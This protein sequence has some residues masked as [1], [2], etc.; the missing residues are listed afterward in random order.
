DRLRGL[1]DVLARREAAGDTAGFD[2]LR[3]EREVLDLDADL[4]L[5][6]TDR[7]R[8]QAAVTGFFA[9]PPEAARI[10]A[11]DVSTPRRALPVVAALVEQANPSGASCSHCARRS[12]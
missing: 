11:V 10:V 2:R 6:G 8:A 12:T 1:A 9:D 4:A 5:A 7:A 3:A